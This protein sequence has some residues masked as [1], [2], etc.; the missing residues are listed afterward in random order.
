MFA[1]WL[2]GLATAAA[3]TPDLTMRWDSPRTYYLETQ[4][5][6]PYVLWLAKRFNE[7]ARVAVVE[8][9]MVTTCAAGTPAGRAIEVA[10][11]LDDVALS[12]AGVPSEV[13]LLQPILLELDERL[14]GATVEL[15]ARSDGRLVNIGM[16]GLERQ[17]RRDGAINENLRLVVSRAFAG[18]DLPLPRVADDAVW[19]QHT[20]WLMRAPAADGSVGTAEVVH[21]RSGDRVLSIVSGGRGVIVPASSGNQ[22]DA[23]MEGEAL[24]DRDRGVLVDRWWTVIANPTPSSRIAEG[25]AGFPYT[26]TGRIVWL[27]EGQTMDVGASEELPPVAFASAIQQGPVLGLI[28]R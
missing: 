25:T 9:R 20:A 28:P 3:P 6:L 13:G 15:T 12:A 14:T 16:T 1:G 18:F 4:V 8:L 27:G 19:M 2:L 24:F 21:R 7:Q 10:C 26:Q 5:E 17:F 11:T 22:Y 23:W